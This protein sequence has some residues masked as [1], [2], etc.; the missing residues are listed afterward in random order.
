MQGASRSDSM[1]QLSASR[2][3]LGRNLREASGRWHTGAI[4]AGILD[5][6][7]R[8]RATKPQPSI[9]VAAEMDA[10]PQA[11]FGGLV[12][13]CR[14]GLRVRGEQLGQHRRLGPGNT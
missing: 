4:M 11:R 7:L 14:Q 8:Y 13:E 3:G 2:T 6:A 1:E 10:C 12:R 5:D 9:D